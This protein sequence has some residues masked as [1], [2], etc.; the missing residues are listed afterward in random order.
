MITPE[1]L[2][3]LTETSSH[4]LSKIVK[5]SVRILCQIECLCCSS[6]HTNSVRHVAS[7]GFSQTV[8]WFKQMIYLLVIDKERSKMFVYQLWLKHRP[9]RCLCCNCVPS[10]KGYSSYFVCHILETCLC[11]CRSDATSE[12]SQFVCCE[13][14]SWGPVTPLNLLPLVWV[15]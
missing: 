10:I 1:K 8:S 11:H 6:T 3:L 9:W 5:A 13:I 15:L 7:N 14:V 12:L 4:F 2:I